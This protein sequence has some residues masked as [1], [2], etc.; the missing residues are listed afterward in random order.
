VVGAWAGY[1]LLVHFFGQHG[2]NI[3]AFLFASLLCG[4]I[5]LKPGTRCLLSKKKKGINATWMTI[6]QIKLYLSLGNL[7]FAITAEY[8]HIVASRSHSCLGK[9]G[10]LC[11][12]LI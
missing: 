10:L 2:L 9:M 12:H 7:Q 5:N 1:Y 8:F 6:F 4:F 11:H 3:V